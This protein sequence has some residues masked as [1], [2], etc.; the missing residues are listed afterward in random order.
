MEPTSKHVLKFKREKSHKVEALYYGGCLS[1]S[2]TLNDE[3]TANLKL[4]LNDKTI[5][6]F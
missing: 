2:T 3:I 5:T 4:A 6:S 1:K